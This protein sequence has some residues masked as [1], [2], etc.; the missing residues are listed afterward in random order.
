MI[1]EEHIGNPREP[2][3]RIALR[4]VVVGIGFVDPRM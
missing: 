2:Q 4:V 1:L 3:P